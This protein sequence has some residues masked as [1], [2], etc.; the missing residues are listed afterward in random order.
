MSTTLKI[1]TLGF[2]LTALAL[3]LFSFSETQVVETTTSLRNQ[4]DTV[5]L[6]YQQ[7]YFDSL[8]NK[9][10]TQIVQIIIKPGEKTFHMD[11][12]RTGR[13]ETHIIRGFSDNFSVERLPKREDRKCRVERD[14]SIIY[15]DLGVIL[16]GSCWNESNGMVWSDSGVKKI[17]SMEYG[18][19][20]E[21]GYQTQSGIVIYSVNGELIPLEIRTEMIK[22]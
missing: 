2:F 5:I 12:R 6:V 4:P 18:L 22:K 7:F 17:Y 13:Q 10:D 16:F 21:K 8:L 3:N 14:T 19:I 9:L 1:L 15:S 20:M 11:N